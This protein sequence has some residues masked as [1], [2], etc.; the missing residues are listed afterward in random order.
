MTVWLHYCDVSAIFFFTSRFDLKDIFTDFREHEQ[1]SKSHNAAKYEIWIYSKANSGDSVIFM[2]RKSQNTDSYAIVSGVEDFVPDFQYNRRDDLILLT[3]YYR[4]LA[5][6]DPFFESR[7][8]GLKELWTQPSS[9]EFDPKYEPRIRDLGRVTEAFRQREEPLY[10]RDMAR[11]EWI[12][13]A[14]ER[15]QQKPATSKK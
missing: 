11:R 12:M 3:M 5:I 9:E 6:I 14:A 2:F 4:Q 7:F 8:M 15:A 13:R 1:I 10:S